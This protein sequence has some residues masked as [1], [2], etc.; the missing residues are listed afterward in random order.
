[1]KLPFRTRLVGG[2]GVTVVLVAG[3]GVALVGRETTLDYGGTIN[4]WP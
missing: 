1:M 2:V 4:R 3:L